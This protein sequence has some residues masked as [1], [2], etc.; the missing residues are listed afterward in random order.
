M[1]D[2]KD[3]YTRNPNKY[4]LINYDKTHLYKPKI[5][6]YSHLI[7]ANIINSHIDYTVDQIHKRLLSETSLRLHTPRLSCCSSNKAATL[8]TYTT[9]STKHSKGKELSPSLTLISSY[10]TKSSRYKASN[11]KVNVLRKNKVCDGDHSE[12]KRKVD[13]RIKESNKVINKPLYTLNVAYFLKEMK[14]IKSCIAN[15]RKRYKKNGIINEECVD[16]VMNVRK[17]MK[18]LKLKM[19]FFNTKFPEKKEEEVYKGNKTRKVLEDNIDKLDE[20]LY[21]LYK[22]DLVNEEKTE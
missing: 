3:K 7:N 19:K 12:H 1:Y 18:M 16:K 4:V 2:A 10:S 13:C 14:R 9:L 22:R 11:E 5:N 21:V 6:K 8:N 20:L 17:D 15:E